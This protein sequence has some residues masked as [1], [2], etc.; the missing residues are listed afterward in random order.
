[1]N[2]VNMDINIWLKD[3]TIGLSKYVKVFALKRNFKTVF[4]KLAFSYA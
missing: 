1:M 2:K 4:K 3:I